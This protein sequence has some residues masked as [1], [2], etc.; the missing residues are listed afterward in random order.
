MTKAMERLN[1]ACESIRERIPFTPKLALVLGSGLGG[2]AETLETVSAIEYRE[3]ADFPHSTVEG[4]RGRFVFARAGELPLVV[5]QGRVH[6]YE[7]YSMEDVV[8][9]I[10]LLW[11]MGARILFLTNASGSLNPEYRAGDFMLI[12]DQITSFVPSP[13]RGENTD[14]WGPRFPD[15]SEVYSRELCS[16]IRGTARELGIPLREGVYVQSQGPQFE[17]PA[18]V[19]MYRLLGGDAVGMSTSCEATAA[20]HLGMKVCGISCVTNQGAGIS[21]NPL[22]AEEVSETADR[23]APQFRALVWGAIARMA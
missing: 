15:M 17:T 3:I 5:M 11:R 12:R 13:L 18:E 21:E 6:Y 4:H 22:S 19:R 7:G 23:V 1:R 9:P 16:L 2:F 10:R 20:C 8:L 14:E